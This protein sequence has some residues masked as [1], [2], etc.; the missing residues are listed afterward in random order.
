MSA[1]EH[2]RAAADQLILRER[3]RLRAVFAAPVAAA[4]ERYF[5]ETVGRG[6]PSDGAR[7]ALADV[8]APY[9]LAD[10]DG[11]RPPVVAPGPDAGTDRVEVEYRRSDLR[12]LGVGLDVFRAEHA[13]RNRESPRPVTPAE[14]A[15]MLA[16]DA[17]CER[18][19]E[20][21]RRVVGV[22]RVFRRLRLG[23]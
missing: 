15:A 11:S 17:A 3:L 14:V 18:A 4:L 5:A 23:G 2:V 19:G 6:L 7:R 16:R 10:P 8:L 9:G 21:P 13:R 22:G 1:D 20:P 12:A